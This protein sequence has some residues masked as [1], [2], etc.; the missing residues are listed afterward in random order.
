[1]IVKVTLLRAQDGKFTM[2]INSKPRH[3]RGEHEVSFSGP[4]GEHLLKKLA[5]KSHAY[6]HAHLHEDN[7]VLDDEVTGQTW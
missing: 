6:F 1:M 5:G 3:Q 4:A 2:E 7:L